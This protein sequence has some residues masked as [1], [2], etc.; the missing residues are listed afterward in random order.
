[1][2]E[3]FRFKPTPQEQT[4]LSQSK[5]EGL[6]IE[7]II[8]KREK[9]LQSLEKLRLLPVDWKSGQAKAVTR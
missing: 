1:M 2:R 4:P 8:Q 6:T 3:L 7:Q 5:V 9:V